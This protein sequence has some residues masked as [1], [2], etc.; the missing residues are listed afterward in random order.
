LPSAQPTPPDHRRSRT[1]Q[2]EIPDRSLLAQALVNQLQHLHFLLR[3]L[4]IKAATHLSPTVYD[5][6]PTGVMLCPRFSPEK[7]CRYP[8]GQLLIAPTE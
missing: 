1:N 8:P 4:P 7:L 6:Q 2:L 5:E 3:L